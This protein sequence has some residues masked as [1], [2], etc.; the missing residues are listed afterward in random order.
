MLQTSREIMVL[1]QNIIKEQKTA[2]IISHVMFEFFASVVY[3]PCLL[4]CLLKY[5]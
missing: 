1:S 5:H 4:T 2:V 3:F